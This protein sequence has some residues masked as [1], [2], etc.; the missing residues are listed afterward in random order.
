MNY[1]VL[2]YAIR[3]AMHHWN[4]YKQVYKVYKYVTHHVHSFF[5]FD[6]KEHMGELRASSFDWLLQIGY[7]SWAILTVENGFSFEYI[8]AR[9]TNGLQ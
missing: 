7:I 4:M 1:K 5:F 9:I 3:I 6:V 2:S 8:T